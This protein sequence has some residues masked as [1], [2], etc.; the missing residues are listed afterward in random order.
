MAKLEARERA[1]KEPLGKRKRGSNVP[2]EPPL[3]QT[4][5]I[6]V[7]LFCGLPLCAVGLVLFAVWK[8]KQSQ[9]RK[10]SQGF[11]MTPRRNP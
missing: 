9:R 5:L 8:N 1:K 10:T 2:P 4:F 3:V 6:A 7:S 11:E